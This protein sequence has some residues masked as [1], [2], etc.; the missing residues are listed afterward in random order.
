MCAPASA[1]VAGVKLRATAQK[2]SGLL[3]PPGMTC[4]TDP[5]STARPPA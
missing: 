5:T 3:G 2:T 4:G 1:V